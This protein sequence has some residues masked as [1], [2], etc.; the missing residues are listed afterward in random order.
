MS[1]QGAVEQSQDALNQSHDLEVGQRAWLPAERL[2]QKTIK[3]CLTDLGTGLHEN[4]DGSFQGAF[5][6]ISN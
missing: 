1:M 2:A 3:Q 6:A 4:D 5:D